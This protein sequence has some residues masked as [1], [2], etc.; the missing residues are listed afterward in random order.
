MRTSVSEIH[1]LDSALYG[2]FIIHFLSTQSFRWCVLK[3]SLL[4]HSS[5][6]TSVLFRDE[7]MQTFFSRS[8]ALAL[9][10]TDK[11]LK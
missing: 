4:Y 10:L 2:L 3:N 5:A 9:S 1:S 6:I 7:L 11:R 8:L